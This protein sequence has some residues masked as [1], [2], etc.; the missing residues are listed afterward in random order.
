MR[1]DWQR[2]T[3]VL[4]I[5][6]VSLTIL[7]IGL[8]VAAARPEGP[9]DEGVLVTVD[10]SETPEIPCLSPDCLRQIKPTFECPF[11]ICRKTATPTA[12]PPTPTATPVTPTA[13]SPARHTAVAAATSV[14]TE[15]PTAAPTAV[16][17]AQRLPTTGGP[18]TGLLAASLL[19][20]IS[21][22]ALAVPG[23]CSRTRR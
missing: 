16:A 23:L 12:T 11:P 18:A 20:I 7:A 22:L 17:A 13:V 2:T 5:L 6:A 1:S 15:T 19:P 10:E 9:G 8:P 3:I 14:P 4:V 21:L